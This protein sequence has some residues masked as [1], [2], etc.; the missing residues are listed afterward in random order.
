MGR[1]QENFLVRSARFPAQDSIPPPG[2][3]L[4]CVRTPKRPRSLLEGRAIPPALYNTHKRVLLWCCVH[5]AR[6]ELRQNMRTPPV[7]ALATSGWR[8]RPHTNAESPGLAGRCGLIHH[9]VSSLV[10]GAPLLSRWCCRRVSRQHLGV[11]TS[12]SGSRRACYTGAV[13]IA[14]ARSL[15]ALLA[16]GV[17][18]G[19]VCGRTAGGRRGRLFGITILG[20]AHEVTAQCCADDTAPG[21]ACRLS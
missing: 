15:S 12:S 8:C 2:R 13:G 14:P 17:A 5:D 20:S 18:A 4:Q 9:L 6:V 16:H 11:A 7:F 1:P 10:I 21:A 19:T 3:F